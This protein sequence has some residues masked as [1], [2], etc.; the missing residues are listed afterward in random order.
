M[1]SP[2]CLATALMVVASRAVGDDYGP[3][4]L[5]ELFLSALADL[6]RR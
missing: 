4:G 2:A 3:R 5:Q 6:V 1:D